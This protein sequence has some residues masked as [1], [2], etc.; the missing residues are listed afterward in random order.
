MNK[1]VINSMY[2]LAHTHTIIS[3]YNLTKHNIHTFHT[4]QY[5]ETWLCH[6]LARDVF[7]IVQAASNHP[8]MKPLEVFPSD[9]SKHILPAKRRALASARVQNW[10][11]QVV[12]ST[13]SYKPVSFWNKFIIEVRC[14]LAGRGKNVEV[15]MIDWGVGRLVEPQPVWKNNN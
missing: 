4:T 15:E 6:S 5:E 7:L 14:D 12:F 2:T 9:V 11:N 10:M 1:K 8:L 13:H 3:I